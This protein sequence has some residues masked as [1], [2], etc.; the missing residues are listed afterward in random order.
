MDLPEHIKSFL[1][2]IINKNGNIEP[3]KELGYEYSQIVT[4]IKNEISDRNAEY[5]NGELKLT[6][7]GI[8]ILKNL[9]NKTNKKGSSKWIEPELQSRISKLDKNDVFLPNKDDLWFN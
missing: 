5:K 7:K 1:L 4:F 9:E 8:E 3:L 2:K 6:P